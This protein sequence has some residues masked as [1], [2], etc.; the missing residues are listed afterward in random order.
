V[1]RA[2][3]D[4]GLPRKPPVT[5]LRP[6]QRPLSSPDATVLLERA[7][8]PL[9]DALRRAPIAERVR[10]GAVT[11]ASWVELLRSLLTIH[12]SLERALGAAAHLKPFD[13]APFRREDAIVRDLRR[14]GAPLPVRSTDALDRFESLARQWERA[15]SVGLLGAVYAIERERKA[16]LELARPVGAALRLKI[17]PRCGLDYLL[18]GSDRAAR[19]FAD[20]GE[21]LGRQV[22]DPQRIRELEHGATETMRTLLELHRA[23]DGRSG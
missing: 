7:I 15:P 17:A 5:V 3:Q 6:G 10:A 20:L 21:W 16:S 2:D 1:P 8:A 11:A 22:R 4:I 23:V 12:R 19:R 18:D 9:A 14:L 13:A